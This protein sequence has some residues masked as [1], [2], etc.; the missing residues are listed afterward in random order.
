MVFQDPNT[1]VVYDITP[2]TGVSDPQFNPGET[3]CERTDDFHCFATADRFNFAPYNLLLTPSERKS[4]FGQVRF[5]FTPTFSGHAKVL[6]NQRE[7][8]NQAAPEPFFL[9]TDAGVYND[10]SEEHTYELQSLMPISYA[11]FCLKKKKTQ[12]ILT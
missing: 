12:K 8:A 10:R 2:N 11:V 7:S 1:G 3:G 9:G 6:Y 5:D 4:V